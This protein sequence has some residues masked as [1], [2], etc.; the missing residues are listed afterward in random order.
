MSSF[1]DEPSLTIAN[2]GLTAIVETGFTYSVGNKHSDKTVIIESGFKTDGATCPKWLRF[3]VPR[4]SYIKAVLVH[5][6]LCKERFCMVQN[7]IKHK[8]QQP[9]IDRE[10][11]I[12]LIALGMPKYKAKLYYYAVRT[13]QKTMRL[14]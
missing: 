4:W 10:F 7:S 14:L 8:M 9:E 2:D 3:A 1:T 12:S 6:K 13:Y 5:D 11:Y